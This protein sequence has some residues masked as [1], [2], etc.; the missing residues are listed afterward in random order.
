MSGLQWNGETNKRIDSW[1][2]AT[3]IASIGAIAAV[4]AAILALVQIR[5]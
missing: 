2:R 1:V 3:I 5:V 4:V